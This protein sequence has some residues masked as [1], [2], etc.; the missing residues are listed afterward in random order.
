MRR[1]RPVT[2]DDGTITLMDAD[3]RVRFVPSAAVRSRTLCPEAEQ[4]PSST[5]YVQGWYA[6]DTAL[7][8]MAP[9]QRRTEPDPRCQ[10]RPVR[11]E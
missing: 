2:E 6:E 9:K 3:G 4:V 1:G 8:W 11:T 7:E 5:V 10:G